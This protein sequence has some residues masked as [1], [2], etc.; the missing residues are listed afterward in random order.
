VGFAVGILLSIPYYLIY[1]NLIQSILLAFAFAAPLVVAGLVA[2]KR[3]VES[4]IEFAIEAAFAVAGVVVFVFAGVFAVAIASE[5][6]GALA[7]A[8]AVAG[9][10]AVAVAVAAPRASAYLYSFTFMGVTMVI[11]SILGGIIEKIEIYETI[12]YPLTFLTGYITVS[13]FE[14]QKDSSKFKEGFKDKLFTDID[15]TRLRFA[16]AQKL[17]LLW[18]LLF[19]WL[20]CIPIYFQWGPSF[21][22]KLFITAAGFAIL[23]IFILRIPDYLICLPIWFYQRRKLLGSPNNGKEM[24]AV[25][26]N[27]L[28]FKHEMIYFQLPGLHKIM[29]VFAGNKEIGIKE[30][31]RQIDHLNRF[32]FQQKQARKSIIT[33][34]KY[35]ETAHQYIHFLLE[36]I[37]LSRLKGLSQKSSLAKFYLMLFE[38]KDNKADKSDD[39]QLISREMKK[40]K[41]YRF[42]EEMVDTLEA[43]HQFLTADTLEDFYQGCKR[44]EKVM[45]YS[46][47]ISY[48]THLQ[49]VYPSLEKIKNSL[50]TIE[51]I[52]HFESKRSF[53]MEQKEALNTLLKATGEKFYQPFQTIWQNV[54]QHCIELVEKEMKLLEGS[55]VLAIQ[56]KNQNIY[57]SNEVQSLYFNIRNKGREMASGISIALQAVSPGI[58]L[59]IETVKEIPVI[60]AGKEKDV[61]L[62]IKAP[63]N[64]EATIKGTLIFSDRIR[65]NKSIPFSFLITVL[66]RSRE[67]KKINNPYVVGQ[68]LTGDAP[69]FI[70]RE[71]AYRFIDENITA[72]GGERHIIVCH[73]LRRTGKTSLL[74]RIETQGLSDKRLV[75]IYF[76][77]Q[78]IDDEKHFYYKL[79]RAIWEKLLL[80]LVP[81]IESFN[82]FEQSLEKIK[83]KLGQHILL[84]M[85]DEFEELQQ[86]VEEKKISKS[87]FG[88]IR[89]LMQH[90]EKLAFLFCGTHKLEEMSADYW[91]IFFNTAIYYRISHLKTEDARRLIIEPV[92]GQLTY[93]DLAVE[94]V[95]KMTNGQQKKEITHW[96]MTWTMPW[97][98]LFPLERK[99]FPSISGTI[100]RCLKNSS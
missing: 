66:K 73:G 5:N 27:S 19:A 82:L 46:R 4:K 12:L 78:G 7:A 90:E 84:L 75:P 28:L 100:Q 54:F 42:N 43:V 52:E 34:G 36:K 58:T 11:L 71:D 94:Q 49:K 60:E 9:A 85:M 33:L 86:R 45:D 47:D 69:L 2:F 89:H 76:D 25:Y 53:I 30:A 31:L 6:A 35:N 23:P 88:H 18:G 10:V 91:S 74:Y 1:N 16:K 21:H 26:N 41:D 67:F 15:I 80:P 83:P 61:A 72:S 50:V 22:S 65:E 87:I 93:D 64:V 3:A 77:I 14:F 97:K 17:S 8:A 32:T 57:S 70:G 40:E 29:T 38:E 55:A 59:G 96:W 20:I 37:D 79:S 39:I 99:A 48:F 13:S 56:L 92:Q 44:L 24:M 51:K 98:K 62:P 68:P 63:S 81:G 95:L